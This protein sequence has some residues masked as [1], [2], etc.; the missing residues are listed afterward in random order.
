MKAKKCRKADEFLLKGLFKVENGINARTKTTMKRHCTTTG[1]LWR[2][3]ISRI[4]MT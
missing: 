4:E 2:L 1:T 3:N